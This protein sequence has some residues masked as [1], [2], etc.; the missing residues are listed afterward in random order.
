M[1]HRLL[2]LALHLAY[3]VRISDLER[4]AEIK[5]GLLGQD[6]PGAWSFLLDRL[7]FGKKNLL[8]G[9]SSMEIWDNTIESEQ[10]YWLRAIQAPKNI[11]NVRVLR[12]NIY[13]FIVCTMTKTPLIIVGKPG[14]SKTLS[15]SMVLNALSS[16]AESKSSHLA[17]ILSL[18][19][20]GS[21]QSTSSSIVQVECV[22]VCVVS[23]GDPESPWSS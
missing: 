12:E 9:K 13:A 10:N 15:T 1:F 8:K 7:W 18:P 17:K 3:E 11:A 2:V 5:K 21:R 20:Q 22:C 19:Y 14:C 4:R 6:G 23:S 16:A